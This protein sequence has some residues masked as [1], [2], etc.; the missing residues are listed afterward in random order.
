MNHLEGNKVDSKTHFVSGANFY[1]FRHQGATIKEFI[2]NKGLHVQQVFQALF[3]LTLM[4]KD[5]SLNMLNF[6]IT[7]QQ[8]VVAGMCSYTCS[9]VI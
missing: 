4:T 8:L 6:H 3:T 5:K 1:M 2:N 9:C 7:H